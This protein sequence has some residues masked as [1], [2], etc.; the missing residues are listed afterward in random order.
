MARTV[1]TTLRP[2]ITYSGP[3]KNI[4]W[5]SCSISSIKI[6]LASPTFVRRRG[7]IPCFDL[8]YYSGQEHRSNIDIWRVEIILNQLYHMKYHMECFQPLLTT[9]FFR[10]KCLKINLR[11]KNLDYSNGLIIL[12][13]II[14]DNVLLGKRR[15][16]VT[17]IINK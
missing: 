6:V 4:I 7:F 15:V 9:F 1:E 17:S 13:L 14:L 8:V 2:L 12:F 10:I 11:F 3:I 16:R 5:P